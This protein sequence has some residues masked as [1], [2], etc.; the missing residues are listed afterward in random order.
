M[1][2]SNDRE[3]PSQ[4][5]FTSLEK[6][7]HR[8]E[9][10]FFTE[11][12]TNIIKRDPSLLRTLLNKISNDLIL[13]KPQVRT[14]KRVEVPSNKRKTDDNHYDQFD[15][16]IESKT[17]KNIIII[18]N[19]IASQ[20]DIGQLK[21]YAV[22][23]KKNYRSYNKILVL[24]TKR[25][26]TKINVSGVRFKQK[27]W[28]EIYNWMCEYKESKHLEILNE[29]LKFM[30]QKGMGTQIKKVNAD[31]TNGVK[32]VCNF[33]TQLN[34]TAS[35]K[36]LNPC[37]KKD[38]NSEPGLDNEWLGYWLYVGEKEWIWCGVYPEHPGW[39]VFDFDSCLDNEKRAKEYKLVP[40]YSKGGD[41]YG[42]EIEIPDIYFKKD[43]EAQ[44]KILER[45]LDKLKD[46]VKI[47]HSKN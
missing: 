6:Y 35:D 10:N 18:E 26:E 1:A 19:K 29:F 41:H 7:A 27:R 15:L 20:A 16:M 23:M 37:V 40:V 3:Q 44:V 31:F 12:F 13:I 38:A 46:K 5:I 43:K 24:I 21:R 25:E 45:W 47:I 9:E 22:W 39:L 33:L 8:Q 2:N 30:E 32:N 14:Q 4:S 17:N 11:A 42:M 28:Y 36:Q 34:T